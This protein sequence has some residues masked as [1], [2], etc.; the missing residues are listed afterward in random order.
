MFK[1]HNSLNKV[2]NIHRHFINLCAVV[3]L[4]ISQNGNVFIRDEINADTLTTET[5]RAT[6]STSQ[7]LSLQPYLWIYNS[8]LFGRS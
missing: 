4:D 7:T 8:R 6:N 1:I 5:T 3:L 2:I